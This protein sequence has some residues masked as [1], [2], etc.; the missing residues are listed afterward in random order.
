MQREA[1][2]LEE[3]Q[4]HS[5]TAS[6]TDRSVHG[7]STESSTGSETGGGRQS[8]TSLEKFDRKT[9]TDY[10]GLDHRSGISQTNRI[11]D[12][13]ARAAEQ[14]DTTSGGLNFNIGS[15]G[16][17]G[18]KG[19][20]T[21][22]TRG[23]EGGTAGIS[24]GKAWIVQQSNRLNRT[25]ERTRTTED[26]S[27]AS[28]GSRNEHAN[29]ESANAS[30]S[31]YDRGGVFGRSSSSSNSSISKEDSLADAY[32]RDERLRHLRE[33]A[34]QL[35]NDISYAETHSMQLSENFNQELADWYRR[36][37]SDNPGLN[38]PGL[39]EVAITSHQRQVR[40]RMI[41]K[42]LEQRRQEL[43][44]EVGSTIADSD[45][46]S[47][48]PPN[49]SET[50]DD[51]RARYR[52]KP[53]AASPIIA[54]AGDGSDVIN[55]IQAGKVDLAAQSDGK[56]AARTGYVEGRASLEAEVNAELDKGFFNDPNLR[57]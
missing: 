53:L 29:G 55:S 17:G 14:T 3:S 27:N 26:S 15:P 18:G 25:D 7:R 45:L 40:D 48:A 13:S 19:K 24:F 11:S 49:L 21:P 4:G 35:S 37:V 43:W 6:H 5:V 2:S 56:R 38:A 42:F 46:K 33:L 30:E 16:R 23:G 32:S 57:K 20:G 34:E 54:T 44:A 39:H 50:F 52:P 31:T 41:S 1:R 36:E 47:I 10:S 8:G 12:S 22:A 9:D 28:D 51:T